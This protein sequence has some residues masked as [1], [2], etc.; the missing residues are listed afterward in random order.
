MPKELAHQVVDACGLDYVNAGGD[1]SAW[2]SMH[3]ANPLWSRPRDSG[4]EI[5]VL[6]AW[7]GHRLASA[8]GRSGARRRPVTR[9][10]PIL[11]ERNPSVFEGPVP[12]LRLTRS[13][14]ERRPIWRQIEEIERQR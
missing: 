9:A 12:V 3:S 7:Q 6:S 14:E 4:P 8:G 10:G 11:K 2:A 5:P 1:A 13:V